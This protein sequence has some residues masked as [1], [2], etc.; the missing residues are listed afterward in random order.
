MDRILPVLIGA[1]EFF[2]DPAA[3]R[4]FLDEQG[5]E[6]LV[7]VEPH[8]WVGTTGP[9]MPQ[10]GDADAI[11]ALPGVEPIVRDKHVSIFKVGSNGAATPTDLPRRCPL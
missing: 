4:S 1:N 3:N 11:A 9:R 10:K 7:V 2:S 8:V 6:Y 5:I